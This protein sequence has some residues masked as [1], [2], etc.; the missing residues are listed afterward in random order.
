MLRRGRAVLVGE[1]AR[2]LEV[3]ELDVEFMGGED[4]AASAAEDPELEP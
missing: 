2:V 4:L 3:V 1:R